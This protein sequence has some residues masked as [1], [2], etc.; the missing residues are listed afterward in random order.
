MA[1]VVALAQDM[2]DLARDDPSYAAQLK[3]D[4]KALVVAITSGT[5]TGDVI[6]ASKNGSSYTMRPG[7]SIQD[8]MTAMKLAIRGITTGYRPSRST[9]TRFS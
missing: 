2:W 6:S 3:T 8:R 7:F 4:H 5:A 9:R 1:D